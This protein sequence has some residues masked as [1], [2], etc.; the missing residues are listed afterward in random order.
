MFTFNK[1]QAGTRP[2]TV[3][4]LSSQY[5]YCIF[6]FG[7]SPFLCLRNTGFLFKV[8]IIPA[9]IY[10][11]LQAAVK[12]EGVASWRLEQVIGVLEAGTSQGHYLSTF[13]LISERCSLLGPY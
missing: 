8:K 10:V 11:V 7:H 12:D 1:F 4:H 9:S 13:V 3:C 5:L 2:V 6:C